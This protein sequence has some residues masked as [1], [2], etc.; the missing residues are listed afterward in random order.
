MKNGN[1]FILAT[2]LLLAP[3]TGLGQAQ[4]DSDELKL[5]ALHALMSAPPERAMP[6]LR[7][8]LDGDHGDRVKENALFVLSQVGTAE[9]QDLLLGFVRDGDGRL[10]AEAIRMVG[11]G[12]NEEA[13]A[14]LAQVYDAGDGATKEAVLEAYLI[15]GDVD[16]VFDIAANAE[17][18]GEFGAAVEVLSA[19]GAR[20]QL[21]QL[22]GRAGAEDA[23]IE[24]FAIAGD[25]ESLRELARDGSDPLRRARAVEAMGILGGDRVGPE[26]VEIYGSA[27]SDAIRDA[28]LDGL[29]IAGYDRGVLE[30]YRASDDKA[31]KRK[32]LETM[33]IMGSDEIWEAVGAALDGGL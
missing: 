29:L 16:A 5:G 23:L 25:L 22:R 33:A 31:E 9:A 11:I 14:G 28:A 8:V 17:D 3:L 19:M 4:D 18:S 26:L 1:A 24:A 6:L 2:L 15:A 7:K 20:E 12:G 27:T 10:R 13:L 21:R 32:L 30:L